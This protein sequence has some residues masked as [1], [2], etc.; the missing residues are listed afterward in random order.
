MTTE[1]SNQ[2][3]LST[4]QSMESRE[5]MAPL[6]AVAPQIHTVQRPQE[7]AV[8]SDPQ[9]GVESRTPKKNAYVH[10]SRLIV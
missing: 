3:E 1:N 5:R 10:R 4:P 8:T 6:T 7:L 2:T 9:A